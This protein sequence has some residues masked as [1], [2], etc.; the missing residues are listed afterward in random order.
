M[1]LINRVSGLL[2]V[3]RDIARLLLA[4]HA[5]NVVEDNGLIEV[6]EEDRERKCAKEASARLSNT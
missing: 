3:C 2:S 6:A 5:I 1:F 4:L